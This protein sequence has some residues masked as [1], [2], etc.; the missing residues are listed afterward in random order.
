MKRLLAAS[1]TTAALFL[2]AIALL[3]AANVVLRDVLSVQI[4]DWFDLSKML[5]AIALFWGIAIATHAGRHIHVDLLWER[6]GDA[7][8]RRLDLVGTVVSLLLLAPLAWMVWVKVATTGTQTTSDLRLPLAPFYAV[9]A[10]GACA[11]LVLALVRI[12]ALAR[13]RDTAEPDEPSGAALAGA[14]PTAA[15][16]PAVSP[17]PPTVPQATAA[18]A[19]RNAPEAVHGS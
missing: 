11:A 16:S 5:Q 18:G 13:G 1:E 15:V 7:G 17:A 4:P 19:T 2:L 9:A 12:A 6:L 8:R 14:A 10:V 3:T